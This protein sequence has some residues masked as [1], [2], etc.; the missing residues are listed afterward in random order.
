M[1]RCRLVNTR[2]AT[3]YFLAVFVLDVFATEVISRSPRNQAVKNCEDCSE[4]GRPHRGALL[5]QVKTRV[6]P[7]PSG[8][9]LLQ[10]PIDI[11]EV[12]EMTFDPVQT[13]VINLPGRPDR[14]ANMLERLR[15]LNETD[16][17]TVPERKPVLHVTR[18]DATN[19][20]VDPIPTDAVALQ[21]STDRNAPFAHLGYLAYSGNELNLSGSERACSMSHL[22]IWRQI[23]KAD[24]G[25]PTLIL[26]DDA[27]LSPDF[28]TRLPQL[29][30]S[31]KA[32]PNSGKPDLVYLGYS[33]GAPLKREVAAGLLEAEYLWTTIG[34]LLWPEGAKKLIDALPVNQPTDNFVA[35]FV[36]TRR[37]RAFAASPKLV[38]PEGAWDVGSDVT[39]SDEK[40]DFL[41]LRAGKMLRTLTT[42]VRAAWSYM[43]G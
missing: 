19:A 28:G 40:L 20:S 41:L 23:A 1:L 38:E 14:W 36:K 2:I 35:W 5:L 29:L 33:V 21:W 7:A 16:K 32:L 27:V 37:L 43:W 4:T 42:P 8:V 13:F 11:P 9:T 15:P 39:H 3:L 18:L 26:E 31:V 30:S 24:D 25:K 6:N 22:R 34:Y 17:T 10:I 12:S